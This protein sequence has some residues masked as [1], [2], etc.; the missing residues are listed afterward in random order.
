MG[1]YSVITDCNT[2]NNGKG[3]RRMGVVGWGVVGMQGECEAPY[4]M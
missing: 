2:F 3:G 1:S 4:Y